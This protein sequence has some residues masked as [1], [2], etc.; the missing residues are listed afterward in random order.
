M[1]ENG[2]KGSGGIMLI[3]YNYSVEVGMCPLCA[4]EFEFLDL[5]VHAAECNGVVE[6]KEPHSSKKTS[7]WEEE[8]WQSSPL[9]KRRMKSPPRAGLINQ[10]TL[11]QS[12]DSSAT[13]PLCSKVFYSTS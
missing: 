13:C 8:Y 10:N 7:S 6:E 5:Q 2:E 12:V 3:G 1:S 4:K 9:K 11:S